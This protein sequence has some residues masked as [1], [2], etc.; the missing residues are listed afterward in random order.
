MLL[1]SLEKTISNSRNILLVGIGGGFDFVQGIPVYEKLFELGKNVIWANLSFTRLDSLSG[2]D[3]YVLVNSTTEDI[4]N[5]NYFPEKYLCEWYEKTHK[6]SLSIYAFPRF[7]PKIIKN[8]VDM[9]IDKHQIDLII[10]VDGGT[11]SLMRGDEP[12]LGT[13]EEDLSTLCALSFHENIEQLLITTV[14]GVDHY[15]GVQHYY[16]LKSVAELSKVNGF[17]GVESLLAESKEAKIYCDALNYIHDKMP[18]YKSIVASCLFE[19]LNST[20]G[21]TKLPVEPRD[22][23]S[24]I[25]PLTSMYWYF[26]AKKVVDRCLYKKDILD[27]SLYYE[28]IDAIKE[29][30]KDIKVQPSKSIKG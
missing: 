1:S 12:E 15:H 2:Y 30:R 8:I 17:Y 27:L 21:D 23:E 4:P 7:G 29:F 19:A 3:K 6:R 16:F 14:F 18:L 24:F 13:P 20:F 5:F 25:T 22:A 11:D 28:V 10:C 9:I 26:D